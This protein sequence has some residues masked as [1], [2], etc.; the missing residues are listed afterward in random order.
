MPFMLGFHYGGL[1]A[2]LAWFY[3]YIASM[4]LSNRQLK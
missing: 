3:K 4:A 2:L 1:S